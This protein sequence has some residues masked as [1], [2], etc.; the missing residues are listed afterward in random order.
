MPDYTP[1]PRGYLSYGPL[2]MLR[3]ITCDH[4]G[5]TFLSQPKRPGIKR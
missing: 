1:A 2:R 4:C 3:Y 5:V